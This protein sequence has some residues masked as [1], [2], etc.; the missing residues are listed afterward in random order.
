MTLDAGEFTHRFLLHTLPD[1]FHR[2]RHYGFL[3]NGGRNDKSPSAVNSLLSA[4]LR[5]IKKPAAILS[6]NA[7]SPSA[8]IAAASCGASM[9]SREPAHATI[10]FVVIRHD[11]RLHH[12][13]VP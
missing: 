7:R 5:L 4:T 8:H 2:I 10:R 11:P 1:G 6:S 13:P 9:S 12:P 3:A